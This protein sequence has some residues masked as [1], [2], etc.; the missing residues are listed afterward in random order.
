MKNK[1]TELIER[2][3]D[4]FRNQRTI[5]LW[6][7]LVTGIVLAGLIGSMPVAPKAEA[8]APTPQIAKEYIHAGS[9]TLAVE[10]YGIT[11]ANPTPTP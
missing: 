6:G 3:K 2:Y 4:S 5:W 7:A 9:R 10:D 1:T 8:Q 11:P